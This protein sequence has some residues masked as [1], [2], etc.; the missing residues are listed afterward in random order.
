MADTVRTL[1][2]LQALFADNE[3][4]DISAQDL[5]DLLVSVY[6]VVV[7]KASAQSVTSST[8]LVDDD[9]LSFPVGAN[10]TWVVNL[11]LFI[12]GATSGDIKATVVGPS[13]SS[14]RSSVIGSGSN[15]TTFENTT[16]NNQSNA[17]GTAPPAGT[18]G[19]GNITV[20]HMAAAVVVGGT[21]GDI[22]LQWAQNASSGTATRVLDGSYLVAHRV[23]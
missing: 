21:P 2:A 5:R 17:L 4:G 19:T 7:R 16:F 14:G 15:A 20:V 1:A 3:N 18:L 6:P 9:E 22:V 10:E 13:G 12:D 8:T 11:Y 23:A